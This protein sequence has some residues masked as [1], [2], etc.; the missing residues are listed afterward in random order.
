MSIL[1]SGKPLAQS[2]DQM[3]DRPKPTTQTMASELVTQSNVPNL[4]HLQS[5]YAKASSPTI[6]PELTRLGKRPA[7]PSAASISTTPVAF[8]LLNSYTT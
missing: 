4:L 5:I 2:R 3:M 7:P 6:V 8:D 1:V